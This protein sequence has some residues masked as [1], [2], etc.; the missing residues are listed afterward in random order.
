[1]AQRAIGEPLDEDAEQGCDR[2][3]DEDRRHNG[4]AERDGVEAEVCADHVDV[5]VR[6]VDELDDAVDH[7]IAERDQR[8]DA[9]E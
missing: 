4:D 2:H 1:M 7:R 6:K 3:R 9:A 8:V 5:A